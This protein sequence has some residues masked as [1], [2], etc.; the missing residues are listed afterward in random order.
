M[1]HKLK[2]ITAA[3]MKGINSDIA[4]WDLPPEFITDGLNFRIEAD[5]IKSTG[6][7]EFWSRPL[8]AMAY[9]YTTPATA[10]LPPATGTIIHADDDLST[11]HINKLDWGTVDRSAELES[12]G[13]GHPFIFNTTQWTITS[14]TDNGTYMSYGITPA[15]Q[16]TPDQLNSFYIPAFK[17][18]GHL[19][20]VPAST[21]IEVL[22]C[23]GDTSVWIYDG[24]TNP[25]TAWADITS[26]SY[27]LG[28][29]GELNWTACQLGSIPLINN[30]SYYPEYWSPQT[31]VTTLQPLL[32][33]VSGAVT[34]QT[35]G[36]A[37]KCI[38]SHKNYVFLL[39][40]T[41]SGVDLPSTYRW[42]H[43]ADSNSLPATFD[44]TKVGFI[45]G[46]AQLGGDSGR[47][48]DGRTLRD[49][50]VLYSEYAVNI[51]DESF[52]EF[53]WRRRN[54]SS[55]FG[56][57]NRNSLVEVKGMH[58]FIG[59]GDIYS[60][61]GNS[62]RSILH[63]RLKKRFTST[64]SGDY[65]SRSY[66]VR[67]TALK[68]VW[69]CI[70]ESG[71]TFPDTAFV[72]NWRDDSWAIQKIPATVAHSAYGAQVSPPVTYNDLEALGVT[73]N[74]MNDVPFDSQ[75]RTPLNQ[76]IIGVCNTNSCLL[77]LDPL[78]TQQ[79]DINS[80][81]ERLAFPLEGERQV[82]TVVRL[83]P[84]M[85]GSTPVNIQVGS[86]K[87]VNGPIEWKPAVQFNPETDRKLD[88]RTTGSHLC[89]RIESIGTGMFEYTGMGIEY[90]PAG[91][92]G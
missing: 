71:S 81:I 13:V 38:R 20:F 55:S 39:D 41:E 91:L 28:V 11:V 12:L 67:N 35:Q 27:S 36:I 34:F 9:F 60:N 69:F 77:I 2:T 24:G 21:G 29:D 66:A 50:F 7:E 37:C 15:S 4:A 64:A 31:K 89:W 22:M 70:P 43:P 62:I 32:F 56:L 92:R 48:L 84:M 49:S 53:V 47:L 63:N 40:T 23:M 14:A 68:E 6:S 3:G 59:D 85:K 8:T 88:V 46:K 75:G 90:S 1:G 51:L 16:H 45:A 72:Y 42:S 58:F 80:F 79:S 82:N 74:D 78:I 33:D 10:T 83:Y 26:A 86:M 73:Y 87:F 65:F 18:F 57:L 25:L 19:H 5:K 61:D 52:D 76:T 44:E 30:P 17:N 54:L